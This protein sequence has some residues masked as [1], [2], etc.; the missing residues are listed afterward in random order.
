MADS[1]ILSL[2]KALTDLIAKQVSIL[3]GRPIDL[4]G[5]VFRGRQRYGAGEPCPMVNLSQ[6]PNID[7]ENN[8]AG[9]GRRRSSNKTYLIQGWVPDDFVNPTDPA[10][11]LMAEV[12]MALSVILDMDSEH[13]MLKSYHPQGR[14]MVSNMNVSTGLVRPPESGISDKA[15]FWLP[16]NFELVENI[17]DPYSYP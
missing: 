13:Y 15:Y 1:Y 3:N 6:A 14:P 17:A 16:V 4:S 2:E 7:I 8:G 10:H 9:D 11:E 5:V 12:K